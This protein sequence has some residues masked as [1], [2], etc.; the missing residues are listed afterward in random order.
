MK[1][2]ILYLA[3][4]V[5][6]LTFNS[7]DKDFE[8][9]NTNPNAFT[10]IDPGFQ[11]TYIQLNSYT[12]ENFYQANIVQQLVYSIGGYLLGA[13][14]NQL[15]LDNSGANF[16]SLFTGPIKNNVDLL[17]K[18]KD[19]PNKTNLYNMARLMKAF[20]FM[21]LVDTY[22]DVPYTEAGLAFIGGNLQPK[23][24]KQDEIYEDLLKEI[25]DAT[26]KLDASKDIVTNDIF[27]LGNIP[28][29]KKFGNSLLL[30]AGMRYAKLDEA[31][32]KAIVQKAVDP[33]RGGVITAYN[34]IVKIAYNNLSPTNG[35]STGLTG[36]E[37]A[38]TYVPKAFVDYLKKTHDPR[39]KYMLVRYTN[40]T[41]S[42]GTG[43]NRNLDYQVGLPP[44]KTGAMLDAL[45]G[46][47]ADNPPKASGAYGYSQYN[48]QILGRTDNPNYL[49]TSAQTLLLLSEAVVRGYISGDAKNYYEQAV[50]QSFIQFHDYSPEIVITTAEVDAY[51]LE[52][53]VA[54]D[55]A[56]ALERINE[57]YWIISF[58]IFTEAWSNF[59]RTGYPNEVQPINFPG[60]DPSVTGGFIRRLVYPVVERTVNTKNYNEVV[61]RIGSDDLGSR[62]FWDIE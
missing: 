52:A 42:Q 17:N 3:F 44:G 15:S 34:E 11:F 4:A 13:N 12:G 33:A 29:W 49:L 27:F 45:A 50:R 37:R 28:R 18:I 5:F 24:D 58:R 41:T 25:E 54:W 9:I 61:A 21:R 48:R 40:P 35:W 22:G 53:D 39:G 8:E 26:N 36:S 38:N 31:K 62:V 20:N 59:R 10:T 43:P 16:T 51:L 60:E 14:Q 57:Q 19:D 1:K 55:A 23:Y 32:A 7:C 47:D 2:I 56:N 6:L 46:T 30:R